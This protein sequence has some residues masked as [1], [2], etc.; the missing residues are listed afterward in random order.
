[1]DALHIH[2]LQKNNLTEY[3]TTSRRININHSLLRNKHKFNNN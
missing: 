1:M 3:T 2:P